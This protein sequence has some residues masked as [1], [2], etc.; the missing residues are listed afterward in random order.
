MSMDSSSSTMGDMSM[1]ASGGASSASAALAFLIAWGIMMAAMMLP[2]AAPMIGLYGAI[3]RNA[4]RTG[5]G[6][7]ATG[8]FALVYVLAWLL[9]GAPG[10]WGPGGRRHACGCGPGAQRLCCR[11]L[12]PWSS[13]SPGAYQF[14]P[15]KIACLR[16]CR[17]PLG[18]LMARWR[19]GYLGTLRLALA[20]AIYC[21]GCCWALD[22]RPGGGRRDGAAWVLLIAALVAAEKLAPGGVVVARLAGVALLA[23]AI[24][25]AINPSSS[26]RFVGHGV[27]VWKGGVLRRSRLGHSEWLGEIGVADPAWQV[28]GQYF[29]TCSCDFLCPCITSGLTAMPTVGACTAAMAFQIEQGRHG[30]VSLDGLRFVV[31]LRTPG[32]MVKGNWS[33]GVITDERATADQQQALV[34]IASGQAGGP[35]AALGPLVGTFLGVESGCD[36]LHPERQSLVAICTGKVGSGGRGRSGREAWTSRC[37]STTPSTPPTPASPWRSRRAAT[38]MRSGWTGTTTAGRT[39]ATSH[40]SPGSRAKS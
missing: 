8:L 16:A 12:L 34:G 30:V 5:Q 38:F 25:V 24:L 39:T 40:P 18:F 7:V 36:Q 15:L 19:A 6:G 31:V 26:R 29:E 2:S 14:S 3:Q 4:G 13:R 1:G 37:T 10:L 33:V 17:S 27:I 32:E 22:G 9:F 20:H 28:S 11:T 35:M 21:V 23:L